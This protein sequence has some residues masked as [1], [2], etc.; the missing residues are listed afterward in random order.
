MNRNRIGMAIGRGNRWSVLV[1]LTLLWG[2]AFMTPSMAGSWF[3]GISTIDGETVPFSALEVVD[4][5]SMSKQEGPTLIDLTVTLTEQTKANEE[6][7]DYP[8]G[9]DDGNA[10]AAPLSQQDRYEQVIQFAADAV[11]E[12]TEGKHALRNVRIFTK[13]SNK[14]NADILWKVA[15]TK[16][17][18]AAAG[19]WFRAAPHGS[20]H[21]NTHIYMYDF[22]WH[23]TAASGN[24]F[25][26]GGAAPNNERGLGYT[27][28]H[29]IGHYLYGVFDEYKIN[30]TDIP[31]AKSVMNNQWNAVNLA[32]PE[33]FDWLNFSI[34]HRAA[35]GGVFG[36][37]VN[38]KQTDQE[39]R[40][41]ESAWETLA[42]APRNA[43]EATANSPG[44][45]WG[46]R[47]RKHFSELA[48]VA[49][50]D[51]NAPTRNLT[52]DATGRTGA[53]EHLNI[54]WMSSDEIVFQ[55]II[56]RSGSMDSTMMSNAK[57]AAKLLVDLA[58]V[59]KATIGV[60]SFSSNVTVNVPLTKVED[61]ASKA[62]IK[63][64]IDNIFA[65]GSTAI[66]EAA[67]AGLQGLLAH[68][69]T[70]DIKA[71]FL[72]T[73]GLNNTGRNPRSVIP[74]YQ[75]AQ[76]PIFTFS[77]GSSA[78]FVL[79]NDMAVQTGGATFTSP[80]SLA[81]V[82]NAFQRAFQQAAGSEGVAAGSAMA[83]D[84]LPDP[85]SIPIH[86]DSAIGR[87]TVAVTIQGSPTDAEVIL[88]SPS[89]IDLA[90]TSET[91]SG[92]Q[93]LY[94]FEIDLPELGDWE[95]LVEALTGDIDFSY[96]A[97]ATHEGTQIALNVSTTRVTNV[98]TYPETVKLTASLVRELPIT[99]AVVEATVT[100][101]SGEAFIVPLLDDGEAPDDIAGD[102]IY[103]ALLYYSQNGLYD[104][105]VTAYDFEG[106]AMLTDAGLVTAPDIDGTDVPPADPI[107]LN[108]DF[109]RAGAIQVEVRNMLMDDHG[110]TPPEATLINTNNE[111]VDGRIDYPEDVDFFRFIADA[112]TSSLVARLHLFDAMVPVFQVY[113]STGTNVLAG[114]D[115]SAPKRSVNGYYYLN[116]PVEAGEE[117]YIS[118]EDED[119]EAF[120]GHYVVAV[121][122]A[123]PFDITEDEEPDEPRPNLW[124]L[125]LLLLQPIL[126]AISGLFLLLW[127]FRPFRPRDPE[128]E[129]VPEEED[130]PFWWP[131]NWWV[132]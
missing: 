33:R 93:T 124:A 17:S 84:A 21:A 99:G 30:A 131:W 58:E 70:G 129:V 126:M 113:D 20:G 123:A 53:R 19:D 49:P 87:L 79:M 82:S 98:F 1:L 27:L 24:S 100:P 47:Q 39:R 15:N 106:Q 59:G 9:D 71:V 7:P 119:S 109:E 81:A 91:Q 32:A 101:P 80:T 26:P 42:R 96:Q 65:S 105:T 31:V 107:P 92:G 97:S 108:E 56:D 64:A 40:M 85:T 48:D 118:V 34:R 37:W 117:Y 29:E 45:W 104:I 102:G 111:S 63:A 128:P 38:T 78:D 130:R 103:S 55:I 3:S 16:D 10:Q 18:P 62:N 132:K 6:D 72:L 13:G 66:G 11:F 61:E 2:L 112:G 94:F 110:N 69:T 14:K 46:S 60:I 4:I 127:I 115:V 51:D 54:V 83:S 86:V 28:A 57:T 73:D 36:D 52:A 8:A 77:Y 50:E 122:E 23:S 74:D 44:D 121:G 76:I 22:A 35:V 41:K 12:M 95:L 114:G 116:V 5:S 43:T 75:A 90:P 68:G 89:G 88:R 25:L 120:L 67:A 125:L